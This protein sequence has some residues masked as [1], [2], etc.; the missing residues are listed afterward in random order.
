MKKDIWKG[1]IEAARNGGPIV[2]EQTYCDWATEYVEEVRSSFRA[3][4]NIGYILPCGGEITAP[5]ETPK[6]PPSGGEPKILVG[7]AVKITTCGTGYTG[8]DQVSIGGETVPF[9]LTP[10][11]G[12]ITCGPPPYGPFI[13]YPEVDIT[14]KY[15][16]GADIELTLKVEEPTDAELSPLKMVEVIDCVGKNI[17]IKES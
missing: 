14:T 3:S 7:K 11:G 5:S 15:G 2:N 8:G 1:F 12:I 6:K 17:F 4:T 16:A 13:K 9:T 10:T